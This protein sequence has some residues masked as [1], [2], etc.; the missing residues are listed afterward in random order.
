MFKYKRLL[1]LFATYTYILLFLIELIKFMLIKSN[2]YGVIYLIINLIIIFLLV[3]T[4][5]N[6]KKY[7]S[8]ARI[9]KLIMIIL[10]GI[11]NSYILEHIYLGNTMIMDSSKEY[12]KNIFIYKDIFKG[13]VYFILIFI[14]VFEFKVEKLL[15]SISKK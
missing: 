7:F 11:F 9:S 5:H 4:A 10:L 12:I 2:V 14:T 8:V 3:P 1:L 15:K 6:Y 13:I